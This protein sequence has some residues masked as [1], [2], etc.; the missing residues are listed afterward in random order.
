[1]TMEVILFLAVLFPLV[2]CNGDT[3]TEAELRVGTLLGLWRH[4][5]FVVHTSVAIRLRR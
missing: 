3:G 4:F 5:I 2:T 1:M